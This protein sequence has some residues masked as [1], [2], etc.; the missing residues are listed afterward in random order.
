MQ[1]FLPFLA[2]QGVGEPPAPSWWASLFEGTTQIY[3]QTVH[4]P[5]VIAVPALLGIL[6]VLSVAIERVAAW[7]IRRVASRT[8]TRVDDVFVEGLPTVVRTLLVFVAAHVVAQALIHDPQ[9]ADTVFRVIRAIGVVVLGIVM[10]RVALRMTDAWVEGRPQ[11]RPVGPGIKLALK[12]AVIPVLLV[13]VLQIFG[14]EIA[15]FLTVL[16]VGSLAV[17]LALQDILKNI[18]SGIQIVLDQP[19]R[20]GDFIV[21]DDGKVRGTVLEV[22]LRSTK[23]RTAENNTVIVPNAT[24]AN[25]IVTNMDLTDRAFVHTITVG[26]GYDT[27]TRR[28]EAVLRE[29]AAQAIAEVEAFSKEPPVVVLRELGD[30]AILFNVAVRVRQFSDRPATV[31][32]LQHRLVERLRAERI[33]IAFPTRTLYVRQDPPKA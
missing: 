17:A 29:T 27:D 22:G 19:I 5:P 11:M 8:Q 21:M 7:I 23:L 26:V 13:T 28:A 6:A 18:F 31:G 9:R 4:H 25:A 30:S 3:G 10:V 24:L 14:I 32:E 12:V 33:E 16:G 20:A 2:Q 1:P 15:A